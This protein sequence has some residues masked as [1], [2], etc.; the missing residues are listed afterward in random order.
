MRKESLS[1]EPPSWSALIS[2][3]FIDA[4]QLFAH[5]LE[6]A[7]IELREDIRS[8][9]TFIGFFLVGLAIAAIGL[10]MVLMML[11]YL[12]DATT[13]VPLWGC[14]GII[15]GIALLIG[16]AFLIWGI[17]RKPDIDLFPQRAAGAVKE[18]IQWISSLIKTSKIEQKPAPH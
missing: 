9:K 12:M 17:N 4:A 16:A 14:F 6:L 7:K 18:D 8:A 2:G 13:I 15:G 11:A 10:F 3:I 5:E 1:A